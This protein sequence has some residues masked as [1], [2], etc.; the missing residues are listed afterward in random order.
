ML[1]SFGAPESNPPVADPDACGTPQD[2]ANV[3]RFLCSPDGAWVNGQV[4]F[5]N[6]GL[7][8]RVW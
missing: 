7:Y 1:F 3:V 2:C 6:G 5:S 8:G 4:V